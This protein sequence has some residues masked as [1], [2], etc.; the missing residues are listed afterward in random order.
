M[1]KFTVILSQEEEDGWLFRGEMLH[2]LQI[3]T[4]DG[5]NMKM[6][7]VACTMNFGSD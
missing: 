5:L 1:S 3:F 7:L 4:E 6:D 2:I